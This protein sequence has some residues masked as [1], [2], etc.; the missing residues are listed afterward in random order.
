MIVNANGFQVIVV[1]QKSSFLYEFEGRLK[2]SDFATNDFF[3][4]EGPNYWDP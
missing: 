4:L 2:E 1:F 3:S